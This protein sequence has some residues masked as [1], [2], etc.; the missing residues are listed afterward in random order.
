MLP[1][2]ENVKKSNIIFKRKG[3]PSWLGDMIMK[4]NIIIFVTRKK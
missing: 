4:K 3:K 2:L 1:H